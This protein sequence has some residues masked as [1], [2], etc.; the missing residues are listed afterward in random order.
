MVDLRDDAL[1]H[2]K[3]GAVAV[4]HSLGDGIYLPKLVRCDSLQPRFWRIYLRVRL[5]PRSIGRIDL[6]PTVRSAT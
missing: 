5:A 1:F 4:S 2:R 3:I 6:Q